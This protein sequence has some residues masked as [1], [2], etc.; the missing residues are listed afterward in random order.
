MEYFTADDP[1]PCK[2]GDTDCILKICNK[3]F[4]EQASEDIPSLNLKRLDPLH[5]DRMEINQGGNSPVGINLTFTDNMIHGLKNM[6]FVKVKGFGKDL[7]G[8]HELKA[9]MKSVSLVGRYSINGKVLILPISGNG[10]SNITLTNVRAILGF[11]GK[12]MEKNGETY[13]DITDFKLSMKPDTSHYHFG[14]LFNGDK[15]LGDNMNAFLNDNS[16]AIYKETSASIDKSFADLFIGII[17]NV[18]SQR[19][20]AK[21]FME[22]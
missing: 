14:N 15:A 11:S 12:P 9:V 6:R 2:F 7:A 8:P 3:I 1:Q 18:F 5:V 19:P 22:K 10:Q 21:L 16:E 13:M 20:Y 4:S 17:K